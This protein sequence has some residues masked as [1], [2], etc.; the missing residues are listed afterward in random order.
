MKLVKPRMTNK[1]AVGPSQVIAKVCDNIDSQFNVV[2]QSDTLE[3][4]CV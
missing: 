1:K 4:G 2:K 3:N